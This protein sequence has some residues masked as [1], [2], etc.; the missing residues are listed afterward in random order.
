MEAL[1][2]VDTEKLRDSRE[3]LIRIVSMLTKMI[4]I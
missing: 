2:L 3:L 4:K 1:Q